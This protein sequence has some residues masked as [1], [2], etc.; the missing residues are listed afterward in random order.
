MLEDLLK[1]KHCF[2]LVCGAGNEEVE[3]I[4]RLVYIYAIAGCRFFDLSA[5]E[6]VIQAAREALE[7][8]KVD[9][10]YLCISVGIKNDPHVNKAVIDYEK[11]VNCGACEEICPQDAIHYAKIRKNKCIGCGRCWKVCSRAAI[12]YISEE[13]N[14]DEVLPAIVE[15]GIDCIEFH[16]MGLDEDEIFSKWK[17]INDNYDGILSICTSRGKLSDEGLV[18]RIKTMIKDRK[19][20]TTIIQADGFPM[21][22]G[23]DNYK[24]TLQAV[25]TAEIVQNEKLP[26][27]L[28][29]SGG[30]NSKTT[31]LAQMCEISYDGVAIGSYARKIV[32]RFI[33][34]DDFW[35]NHNVIEYALEVAKPLVDTVIS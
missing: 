20:Y 4:K 26:V 30:T 25:A 8:A 18:N 15:K 32:K 19:P 3:D 22:G 10:A 27:Y 34:R 17:Y 29:L 5:N 12:S 31:E 33:D 21:S 16:A 1:T 2:K 28:V 13:K 35:T 6:N 23:D 9:D 24:S 7:L 14:L 11:C